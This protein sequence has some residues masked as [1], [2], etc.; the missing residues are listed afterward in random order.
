LIANGLTGWPFPKKEHSAVSSDSLHCIV[1]DV[2]H[3]RVQH[4]TE[5]VEH[6]ITF[7]LASRHARIPLVNSSLLTRQCSGAHSTTQS[8]YLTLRPT[9]FEVTRG[10][11]QVLRATWVRSRRYSG[12]ALDC[13]IPPVYIIVA[14][15][16]FTSFYLLQSCPVLLVDSPHATLDA[17]S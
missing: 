14:C 12:C 3:G 1:L 15:R 7:I 11:Q 10:S 8:R 4:N 9:L 2:L 16:V 6:S 17:T 5:S 13:Q